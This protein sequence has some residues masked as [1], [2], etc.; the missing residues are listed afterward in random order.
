M[1]AAKSP[2]VSKHGRSDAEADDVR[3]R[4]ELHAKFGVGAGHARDAAVE[5]V[6]KN[7]EANGAGSMVEIRG[8]AA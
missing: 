3:E 8:G 4:I 6:E 7:G 2:S 5:G 1:N